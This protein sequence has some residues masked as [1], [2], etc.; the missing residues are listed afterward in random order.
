MCSMSMLSP[1]AYVGAANRRGTAAKPAPRPKVFLRKS[2]L[3]F[4][5]LPLQ[6]L[7][8]P[9][10]PTNSMDIRSKRDARPSNRPEVATV[11]IPWLEGEAE[12][13]MRRMEK[14]AACAGGGAGGP[15]SKPHTAV[16]SGARNSAVVLR[17]TAL[18]RTTL[19]SGTTFLQTLRR[20]AVTQ[21]VW[22][23]CDTN[24]ALTASTPG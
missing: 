8:D 11:A 18:L 10:V 14:A 12:T 21:F 22:H 9:T 17:T 5:V 20:S 4:M 19:T 3:F 13:Q 15:L 2:R 1:L 6:D 7:A 23:D 24:T 16:K